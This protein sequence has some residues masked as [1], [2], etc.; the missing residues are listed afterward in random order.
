MFDNIKLVLVDLKKTKPL[1]LCLT[2]FVTMD[3]MA[4][5]LLALGAAPIMS[6]EPEEFEELVKI[7]QAININIGT[8]DKPFIDNCKKLINLANCHKKPIIFGLK[9]NRTTSK[10]KYF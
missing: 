5:A 8:L 6:R 1:I 7:S 2:N 4:N 3:F 9:V 10:R